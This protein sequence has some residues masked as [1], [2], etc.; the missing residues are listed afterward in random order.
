MKKSSLAALLLAA[1]AASACA[2]PAPAPTTPADPPAANPQPENPQ[3]GELTK[4]NS[5][6]VYVDYLSGLD[7]YLTTVPAK[8]F[9]NNVHAFLKL[10][11]VYPEVP[12]AVMGD[13]SPYAGKFYPEVRQV[14][15]DEGKYF[16]RTT[17]TG[18]TP[19]FAAWL[20]QTGR[21][22]VIIGGISIDNCTLH[23][24]L[25][26]LRAGYDVH[27]VADVS[28]TNNR[29][30]EEAALR[31]L[32]AAGAVVTTWIAVGT[33]LVKDWNSPEGQRL[34]GVLQAHLAASTVGQA[35]DPSADMK[36]AGP[37]SVSAGT[38]A[39]P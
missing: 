26:L 35:E 6:L 2:Q 36:V 23:T 38:S 24:T 13:E 16:N 22:K 29:L 12:V 33:E 7:D 3:L 25:D 37:S 14:V 8:Q 31:R 30:A 1:V 32:H 20:K 34:M 18:Y 5:V 4:S 9:R 11:D 15:G 17:P 21:K 39:A 28:S 10:H 19:E 27:V